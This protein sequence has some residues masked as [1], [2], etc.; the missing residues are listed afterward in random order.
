[1]AKGSASFPLARALFSVW[2]VDAFD[3]F[4]QN[5]CYLAI[6]RPA[7]RL[8]FESKRGRNEPESDGSN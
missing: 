3:A 7:A 1:M 5:M 4:L 2:N 6:L 8:R